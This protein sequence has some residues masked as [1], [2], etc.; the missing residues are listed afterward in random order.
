MQGIGTAVS[1]CCYSRL[2][3][4]TISSLNCLLIAYVRERYDNEDFVI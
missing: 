4:S 1:F 3:I 2:A